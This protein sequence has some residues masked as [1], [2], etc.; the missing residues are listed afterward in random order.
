MI[1]LK[2]ENSSR[3]TPS[4]SDLDEWAEAFGL[5]FPVLA[6]DG[7]SITS[8]FEKDWYIPSHT[9]L[10][11]GLKVIKVDAG[12]SDSDIEAALP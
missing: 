7:F 8:R 12:I 5:T 1:H 6:D 9:L 10:G 3:D 4:T 2:G 11:P